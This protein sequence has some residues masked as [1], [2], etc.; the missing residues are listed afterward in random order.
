[1]TRNASLDLFN[2]LCNSYLWLVYVYSCSDKNRIY[3][4]VLLV[5]FSEC[6]GVGPFIITIILTIIIII[7]L[8]IIIIIIG[9]IRFY[10]KNEL[11]TENLQEK[12][13]I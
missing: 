13:P 9:K 1:M 8:T 6:H 12:D 10:P 11:Q 3:I 2:H 5:L 4:K 7:I